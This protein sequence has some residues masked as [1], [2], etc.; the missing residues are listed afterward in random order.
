M[1][2]EPPR[3]ADFFDNRLFLPVT[4]RRRRYQMRIHCEVTEVDEQEVETQERRQDPLTVTEE[5]ARGPFRSADA[6]V[7]RAGTT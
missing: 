1:V 7:E 4:L 6:G 3:M 5:M 2:Q